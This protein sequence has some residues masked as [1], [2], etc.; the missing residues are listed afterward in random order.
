MRQIDAVF[1]EAAELASG[2]AEGGSRKPGTK[3][4][5]KAQAREMA[6]N[7]GRIRLHGISPVNDFR[8]LA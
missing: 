2:L 5:G 3:N 6:P 8:K 1:I 7:F 4:G